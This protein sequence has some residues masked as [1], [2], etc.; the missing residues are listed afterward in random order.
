MLPLIIRLKAPEAYVQRAGGF[1]LQRC[2]K[3]HSVEKPCARLYSAPCNEL[4][5]ALSLLYWEDDFQLK[6]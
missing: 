3:D 5:C 2:C 1:A 4:C 6:E